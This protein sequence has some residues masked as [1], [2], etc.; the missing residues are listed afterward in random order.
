M[1]K[2]KK[3]IIDLA[4][5]L[6]AAQVVVAELIH[7]QPDLSIEWEG[8]Q[9]F[10]QVDPGRIKAVHGH[11]E[12]A[13]RER[14]QTAQRF[15]DKIIDVQFSRG[16]GKVEPVKREDLPDTDLLIELYTELDKVRDRRFCESIARDAEGDPQW[17]FEVEPTPEW[18][19]ANV[20]LAERL[21]VAWA[22][23]FTPMRDSSG[24]GSGTRRENGTT[25]GATP[26]TATV[27][28]RALPTPSTGAKRTNPESQL[29]P[30]SP[31]GTKT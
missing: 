25:P 16:K 28:S 5:G 17:H 1:A 6:E 14:I 9:L 3:S 18:L 20:A 19:Q 30:T 15:Q 21:Q 10:F 4:T 12:Q 24:A 22:E 27:S 11:H 26:T 13:I 23:W 29:P 7:R 8:H 2:Y 31:D